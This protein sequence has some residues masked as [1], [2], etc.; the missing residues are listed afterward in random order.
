MSLQF[1]QEIPLTPIGIL[2]FYLVVPRNK[3]VRTFCADVYSNFIHYKLWVISDLKYI[4]W[5]VQEIEKKNV[6][7]Y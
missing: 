1:L 2:Q 5:E 3:I 4:L 6:V 7:D